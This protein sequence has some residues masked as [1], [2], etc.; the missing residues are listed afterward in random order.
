MARCRCALVPTLI[1]AMTPDTSRTTSGAHSSL[2]PVLESLVSED[3]SDTERFLTH[4][5]YEEVYIFS[6]LVRL[7][8]AS[9]V[10]GLLTDHAKWRRTLSAGRQ[11][12]R[13]DLDRHAVIERHLF[14]LI[15]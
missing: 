14:P 6:V 8:Y 13:R 10:D 11:I 7:G 1:R 4:L 9:A 3:P 2:R 15:G 5:D 12:P